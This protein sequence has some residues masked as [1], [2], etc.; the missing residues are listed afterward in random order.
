VE[1]SVKKAVWMTC[2][3]LALAATGFAQAVG[4]FD[5]AAVPEPGTLLLM[6][7]GLAGVGYFAWRRNRNK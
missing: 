7:A 6:A 5:S 1:D 3:L 2:S 4:D